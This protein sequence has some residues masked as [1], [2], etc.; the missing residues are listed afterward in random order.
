MM[1]G[2]MPKAL[3]GPS[4]TPHSHPESSEWPVRGDDGM[5]RDRH[6]NIFDPIKHKMGPD[7][8]PVVTGKGYFSG[9]GQGLER[10]SEAAQS[11][12]DASPNGVSA[13]GQPASEPSA[14]ATHDEMAGFSGFEGLNGLEDQIT[15]SLTGKM[16]AEDA[17][18]LWVA[19][20]TIGF[21][22]ISM[23][24]EVTDKHK[25]ILKEGWIAMMQVKGVVV[26]PWQAHMLASHVTVFQDIIKQDA[27]K[28]WRENAGYN[29]KMFLKWLSPWKRAKTW[30]RRNVL[31]KSAE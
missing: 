10:P 9:I 12:T 11:R 7:G 23:D 29:A 19:L 4:P 5:W 31:T 24:I 30:W 21:H 25:G 2:E 18:D 14:T 17:A 3:P 13:S 28:T 15:D 6:R 20:E 26:P 22:V 27:A 8:V 16:S 1:L